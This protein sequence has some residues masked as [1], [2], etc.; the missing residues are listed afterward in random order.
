MQNSFLIALFAALLLLLAGC[1]DK[2]IFSKVLDSS[3]IGVTPKAVKIVGDEYGIIKIPNDPASNTEIRVQKIRASCSTERA[4]SLGSDFDGYILIEI[5]LNGSLA[6]KAQMDF[7]TEPSK[8]DFEKVWAELA[9][10]LGW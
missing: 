3:I 4:R 8:K 10:T 7:K 6:A 5:Y 2:P 1:S 9:G